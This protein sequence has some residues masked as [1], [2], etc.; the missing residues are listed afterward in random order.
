MGFLTQFVTET[1]GGGGLWL[2]LQLIC[3]DYGQLL[4]T[5]LFLLPD[6]PHS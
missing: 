5:P 6:L 2:L 1:G 4:V 3:N